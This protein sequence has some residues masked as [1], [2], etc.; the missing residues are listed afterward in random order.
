MSEY[1]IILITFVLLYY[2]AGSLRQRF[3][4]NRR[5]L[6]ARDILMVVFLILSVLFSER[7]YTPTVDYI[8]FALTGVLVIYFLVKVYKDV[9]LARNEK[10]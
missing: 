1:L 2:V 10:I 3:K 9:Q 6:L 5:F 4:L 8:R 7:T